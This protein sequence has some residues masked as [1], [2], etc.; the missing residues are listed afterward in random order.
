M[1]ANIASSAPFL[2]IIK[3]CK[4]PILVWVEFGCICISTVI[5]IS[6]QHV[7]ELLCALDEHTRMQADIETDLPDFTHERADKMFGWVN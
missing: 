5:Y 4:E 6:G 3:V 7:I 1:Y 2:S